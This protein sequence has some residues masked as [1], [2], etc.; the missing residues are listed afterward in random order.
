MPPQFALMPVLRF[1]H[2]VIGLAGHAGVEAPAVGQGPA[3]VVLRLG[4]AAAVGGQQLAEV[5]VERRVLVVLLEPLEVGGLGVAGLSDRFLDGAQG[6][7]ELAGQRDR[8][9]AL[10]QAEDEFQRLLALVQVGVEDP[11]LVVH[12]L[13]RVGHGLEHAVVFLDG[14]GEQ[15]CG[16]CPAASWPSAMASRRSPRRRWA[17]VESSLAAA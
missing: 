16:P 7:E 12:G 15:S 17:A 5:E 6:V 1:W 3:Q 13:D 10:L 11:R 14:L 9:G 8:H 2:D 4:G